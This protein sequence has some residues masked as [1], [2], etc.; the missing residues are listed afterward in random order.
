MG[1]RILSPEVASQIAAGEVVERPASVVKELVENSIDADAREIRVEVGQ[2]GR[3]LIR[4]TDDGCGVPAAEAEL[5]FHRHSTSKLASAEDLNHIT[6]LGFRGEALASIAAVSR[7]TFLT[8]AA[9]EEA[10]TLLR[11]EGGR[12]VARRPV[13][14]PPGTTVTVEDLFYNVPARRKFLRSEAT[15]RRHIDAWVTRYALAYPHLRF[16]LTHDGR[17]GFHSPGSGDL[18]DVLVAVHGVKT[19][20]ALLEIPEDP[21]SGSSIRVRGFV[22]PPSLHRGDRGGITLFVNGRWIQDAR[23][24]YAVIQAYHTLLPTGR[25]PVATI[26]ISLPPEEVDVNVHP[27]KA[28]VRFQDGNEVFRVVQRA[29]RRSVLEQA[30]IPAASL[31]ASP[32]WPGFRPSDRRPPV[33]AAQAQEPAVQP[34]LPPREAPSGMPLLRVVGQVGA[35]YIIAEG[36]DGLYLIDQHAAHERVLYER[37]MAQREEGVPSQGLLE[38]EPVDL[39]PETAGLVEAHRESLR[40]LGFELEPFGGSTFLV[41]AL[42]AVLAHARAAEVLADVARA[43]QEGRSQVAEETEQAVMRRVCKQAAVKA[44]QVLTREE[45]EGL[46]Q[47][48]ERCASP[49]TCP[50]GRP[51]MIHISV[52][53]LAREFGRE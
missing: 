33:W 25:Y 34:A 3:R 52:A 37:M 26:F 20:A 39:S 10:G 1:I 49:R 47:A 28:E 2:G 12:V 24:A 23:L 43:L 9:E 29:V 15:E 38:P 16:A 46:V 17:E 19:G 51:T 40:R 50:H 8:R 18:R 4:V 14:R 32:T 36:P 30:H 41:R 31:P 6:T 53:Q 44:G 42:P 48:L 45:M 35:A 5:A 11:L 27:A 13:G 21:G 7:V 22:G